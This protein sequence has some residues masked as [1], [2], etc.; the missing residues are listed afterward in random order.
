MPTRQAAGTAGGSPQ[1]TPKQART[2]QPEQAET[3]APADPNPLSSLTP[4]QVTQLLDVWKAQHDEERSAYEAF[5]RVMALNEGH[6]KPLT[7]A[8][9]E[10][11]AK[12]REP[13]RPDQIAKRPQPWCKACNAAPDRVC[14]SHTKITCKTCG[15]RITE[16]HTDLDYV[17]HAGITDRLLSVDPT[18]DWEPLSVDANGLPF[19]DQHGGLWIRLTVCGMTRKGYG[20]A[21]GKKSGPTAVKEAIGDAIRNAAMRFGMALDL[22]SKTDLHKESEPEPHPADPFVERIKSERIWASEEWLSGVRREADEAGQLDYEVPGGGGATLGE[23]IDG[24]LEKLAESARI[25]AELRVEREEQRKAAAAQVAVEHGVPPQSGPPT[26]QAP[27]GPSGPPPADEGPRTLDEVRTACGEV[28]T[29]PD[30]LQALLTRAQQ[31]R[32][33]NAP[34]DPNN[35]RGATLGQ[36]MRTQIN[37]LRRAASNRTGTGQA[38]HAAHQYADDDWGHASDAVG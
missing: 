26:G 5:E 14:S 34:S 18:W 4:A 22:W 7:P 16:A 28:W 10:A 33:A 23:I 25:A 38:S 27:A 6:T 20:D 21:V 31:I 13:F 32:V 8:Q 35:P 1:R 17:G 2:A 12:L 9:L 11:L 24:Q 19:F 37:G 3:P 29:D 30:R 15:T 36:A